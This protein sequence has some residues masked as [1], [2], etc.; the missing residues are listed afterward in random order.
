MATAGKADRVTTYASTEAKEAQSRA[1]MR[2]L[3]RVWAARGFFGGLLAIGLGLAGQI[4]LT[5]G[6]DPSAAQRYY[7][8]ALIVLIASFLHP[9]WPFGKRGLGTGEQVTA[10]VDGSEG[11][12]PVPA[13][14]DMAGMI[15]VRAS[16]EAIVGS[17]MQVAS[18]APPVVSTLPT[19]RAQARHA[20]AAT[21][22][23]PER[24][25]SQ[26]DGVAASS[27]VPK[28]DLLARWGALRASLG[29][30]VTLPGLALTLVLAVASWLVLQ[31]NIADPLGGWLWAA[32]LAT[33]IVTTLGAPGWPRFG[34]RLQDGAS[35]QVE[36]RRG[37]PLHG[38]WDDFF[39]RG[40]P[41]LPLRS[42]AIAIGGILLVA[43][44]LRLINLEYHPGI[45]GDEG[46]RG[47]VARA[48]NEGSPH[49]MWD[50]G[51][52]GVPNLYFYLVAPLL[53][54]FGDNMV[55]DRMLSVISGVLAV[56][57]CYKIGRLL[58]GPRVGLIAGAMLAFSPLALQFS[59][60]AGESTPTG[61]L[62]VA[63]FYFFFM[64][65]RHRRWSDWAL[66]GTLAGFSLYFYAAGKLII[67]LL[68]TLG[69]Y[70]L[71]RWHKEFFRQYALGFVL[72][73][74]A[75]LLTFMPYGIFSAKNN[76]F[77]FVGRAN[78]TSIFSPGNQAGTF[79]RYNLPY[80][81]A[82]ANQS[83]TDNFRQNPLAW[84]G[85]LFQQMREATDVFHR[86]SDQVVFYRHEKNNGSMFSPM[87]AVLALL[88]LGYAAWKVFD[89][90][91]ALL[92]IMFWWGMAG[93]ALTVDTPNL[94]R[95]DGAWPVVML[96]PALILDRV[97][98]G[99][100]PL[101]L[102]LARKWLSVPIAALLVYFGVDSYQEYF[103]HY[104]SLC[105]Y[106]RDTTQA[107]Y[108]LALGQDYKAY[109]MGAG[110]WDV[111][112]GYGSTRFLAKGVE[113]RD[114]LAAPDTLPITDNNGKGAAFI[115]YD[116][117]REYLPILRLMYPGG[118]EEPVKGGDD[119]AYFTSYKLTREQLA[120]FQ[121]V[122]VIT[123]SSRSSAH[124][125]DVPS[126]GVSG[127]SKAE[128][129]SADTYLNWYAGV[130]APNYG[131]YTFAL[132]GSG[133]AK[134]EIDGRVVIAASSNS[135]QR[136]V[137][138][139]LAKGLHDVSLV[140]ALGDMSNLELLW[141]SGGAP[142]APIEAQYLYN[143]PVGG[144]SAEVGSLPS[145]DALTTANPFAEA[146]P[147]SRRSDP[148]IGYREGSQVFGTAP[149]FI[150]WQGKLDAPTEGD[151][152]FSVNSNGPS[153]VRI[154]GQTVVNNGTGSE[155]SPGTVRLTAGQHDV[156]IRYLWQNGPARMEWLWTPPG[157][158]MELVPPTVLTPLKRSWTR[159]ELPNAP[160]ASI[161][162]P[163]AAPE[164]IEARKPVVVLGVDAGLD[165]PRGLAVD[166]QGNIYIGDRGNHRVVVLSAD[167]KVARTVGKAP[168]D[169]KNP[170]QGELE[171]I[172][173]VAVAADGSLYV[174]EA[175]GR[176][177]VFNS[178]GEVGV[179]LTQEQLGTYAP[180]GLALGQ[181]G[182]IY[183]ADTGHS[184]VLKL[185][186]GGQP[187]ESQVSL[188]GSDADKAE[189]PV[190]AVT[191]PA[192]PALLY[193]IDLK[194]RIAQFGPDNTIIKQWRT[195]VGRDEGGA[196]KLAISPDGGT[197][198]M[199]DP[200]RQRVAVLSVADG[201]VTYF[202]G[203]G[204][205]AGQ[206]RSPSGIA[207]G[208]DGRVYVLDRVLGSVQVF[209]LS[210]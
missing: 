63:S 118:I 51:W 172:K 66:A 78:E 80:D 148:F 134:L 68:A 192:N 169:E 207:V 31:S 205:D 136:Q 19:R 122:R 67:P 57:F 16:D 150:R 45:F 81:P 198:Y 163:Q 42:E 27:K 22:S 202:G 180:N 145:V 23:G 120:T 133:G 9:S 72:L 47:M 85:L 90:R 152:A 4:S 179:A 194:D 199:S 29:W 35:V 50:A 144:L 123:F 99:A 186:P 124:A 77:N 41:R 182:S 168:A 95:I 12:A 208:Q 130:I 149:I 71:I 40:V 109:Q 181:D 59:R 73:G 203:N 171:D 177:Q 200:D 13:P 56:W 140:G 113:G 160:A 110:G 112:F 10:V 157:G 159:D 153:I 93:T 101:N 138:V 86:R 173:D 76:W 114:M 53:R 33:L 201:A 126:F 91:F 98:A 74:V 129:V 18:A 32:S 70:C 97:V 193:A 166:G 158:Q 167:G 170:Q 65:L 26:A 127:F 62:W 132:N 94:Q 142:P 102:K 189:Q 206:F 28:R 184:R 104:A 61:T 183:V 25:V 175:M 37:V 119:V 154:N 44:I 64:A 103:V 137:E 52:W 147:A 195:P 176:V 141:S 115:I 139:V 11:R 5:A 54:I 92:S 21:I 196:S 210:K 185:P 15:A 8:L 125:R 143:G 162:P 34:V 106:C 20:H 36:A 146:P 117:N 2:V 3:A 79:G 156:D 89:G 107:R 88:G 17:A 174:L 58:W 190:D 96:F 43:L 55:G 135:E 151:Y 46:E 108:A 100:W 128:A 209:D 49:L 105:P 164:K 188:T 121:T 178:T 161:L 131:T 84:G 39:A 82:W 38:P 60:L 6:N 14:T 111:Y 7:L 69:A 30:R 187:L 191:D 155:P 197:V 83:L 24:E 204:T 75:F 165:K 87:W 1:A 48:I 116:N